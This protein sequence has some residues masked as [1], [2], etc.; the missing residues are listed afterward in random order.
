MKIVRVPLGSIA[1]QQACE[2]Y[3]CASKELL[4]VTGTAAWCLG[5]CACASLTGVP[6]F[7]VPVD[8]ENHQQVAQNI[9]YDGEDE[10]AAKRCGDP[11]RSTERVRSSGGAVHLT[12]VQKHREPLDIRHFSLNI[13]LAAA[14]FKCLFSAGG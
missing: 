11:R 1:L 10:E 9:H 7:L 5:I 13:W 8:G 6:K 4:R 12:P 14:P 3:K 2:V